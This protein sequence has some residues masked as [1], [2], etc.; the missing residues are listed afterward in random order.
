MDTT[1]LIVVVALVCVV[2]FFGFQWYQ[3]AQKGKMARKAPQAPVLR[4]HMAP[5]APPVAEPNLKLPEVPGQSEQE[6]RTKEPLQR[7]DAPTPQRPVGPEARSVPAFD[8]SLRRPEQSFHAPNPQQQ[9]PSN[10]VAAGRAGPGTSGN[11]PATH[12]QNFSP[13][14]A[15][16]GGPI[17]GSTVFAFDGAE[18][19]G[20]ASF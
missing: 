6:L 17:V 20:Y 8:D 11:P 4:E 7:T 15:Q 5:V 13:E 3:T 19:M 12:V 10:D 18:P 16:N 2:G 9:G 1:S 14:M